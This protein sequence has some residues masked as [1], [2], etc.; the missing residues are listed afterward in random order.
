MRRI[1]THLAAGAIAATAAVALLA[2]PATAATPAS[3]D[4]PLRGARPLVT[5]EALKHHKWKTSGSSGVAGA[6]AQGTWARSTSKGKTKVTFY[7]KLRDTT[8][9]DKLKPALGI[10]IPG[11]REYF[12]FLDPGDNVGA[13]TITFT[14]TSVKVREA[15]GTPMS[16]TYF[17]PAR[18]GKK[19][20]TL[21]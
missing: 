16:S 6:A 4:H 3:G 17:K 5:I 8:P 14:A 9:K 13:D 19:F 7:L 21:F 12:L 10:K 18:L 11:Q 20:K 1:A 15:V 2:A